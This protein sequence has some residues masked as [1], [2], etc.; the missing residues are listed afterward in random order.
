VSSRTAKFT[1]REILSQ[2]NKNKDKKTTTTK[3]TKEKTTTNK[4]QKINKKT[5]EI[6]IIK[7]TNL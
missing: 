5:K 2:K 3:Q 1:N 7:Y 6:T 4:K